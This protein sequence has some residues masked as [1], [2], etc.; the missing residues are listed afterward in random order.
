[1]GYDL[2]VV[3]QNQ[4][5]D[6]DGV[7]HSS[8]SSGLLPLEACW[9]RVPQSSLKS[10][11]GMAWIVHVASSQRSHGSKVKDG[12]FDGIGCGIVE[13]RPNYPSLDV[14]FLLAHRGN[15]VFWFL[16]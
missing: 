11:G 2:S 16:L 9:A 3:P 15:L 8:K 6:E 4:R 13:V 1:M 5:E 14:I 7:G 10:G 12:R